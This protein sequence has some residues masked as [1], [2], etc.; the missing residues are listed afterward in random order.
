M[1][2]VSQSGIGKDRVFQLNLVIIGK[3]RRP[4]GI[5]GDRL[6]DAVGADDDNLRL[7]VPIEVN[8]NMTITV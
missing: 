4:G 5:N 7:A 2:P 1:Q 3:S 6:H 8:S